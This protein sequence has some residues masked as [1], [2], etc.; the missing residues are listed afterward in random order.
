M[1]LKFTDVAS[2]QGRYKVGSNGEDGVI[3]KA[4]EG[5]SYVNPTCDFVAQQA[6]KKGIPWGL[7]HYASGI[8]PVAEA[9]FFYNNTKGYFN[10][11]N[12]PMAW[13][14][15]EGGGNRAWGNG[16]WASDFVA[17]LSRL[18]GTQVGI[19]T[20][21]DGVRQTQG[22]L[23]NKAA[24]WFAGYPTNANVGWSPSAFP[25]SIGSWKVLTGWQFSSN[26]LDKSLFYLDKNAWAKLAG[27]KVVP[28]PA[29]SKPAKPSGSYSV[30][31]KSLEQ[32]ADDV[33]AGRVGSG[34]DRVK[35]LGRFYTGAQA[36][37]NYRLK[38]INR[39]Q[40]VQT[41]KKETLTG[42]Y[43]NGDARKHLLG[44]VYNE[45]QAAI[46]GGTAPKPAA[47]IKKGSNVRFSQA[48]DEHGTH[49]AVSGV[50]TVMELKGSRAVVGRG[51]VVTAATN[52][53]N[54]R[55]A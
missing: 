25:Y 35:K 32:M 13:L 3:V 48:V 2:Y 10:Q 12:R 55:L 49:L 29:P 36:C 1:V 14:D 8:D 37:V 22:Y 26:P 51:G 24:L 44:T 41:L 20:G 21:G 6:I 4:T 33:Q 19:Y 52:V 34:N 31:G 17:E 9:R 23:A 54:L 18:I 46:N 50:Y 42:A 27:G 5:T 53:R 38:Q 39:A 7:Y 40:L 45:V 15:W 30:A 16:K 11:D 47:T 28:A 43:G